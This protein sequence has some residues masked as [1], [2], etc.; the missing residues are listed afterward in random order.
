MS[1]RADLL[2]AMAAA[3]AA[4]FDESWTVWATPPDQTALPAVWAEYD[5]ATAAGSITGTVNLK[6]VAVAAP[7]VSAAMNDR[8]AE[9]ADLCDTIGGDKLGAGIQYRTDF[10]TVATIGGVEHTALNYT[11]TLTRALPC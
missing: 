2:E 10:L 3:L 5:G 7:Q 11:F 4:T 1:T 9:A 8:L 6:V